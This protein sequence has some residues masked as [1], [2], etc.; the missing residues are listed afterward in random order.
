SQQPR[1]LSERNDKGI[2][3]GI[4]ILET[5]P[6]RSRIRGFGKSAEQAIKYDQHRAIVAV[7]AL[8]V[9]GVMDTM[10][11]RGIE[12]PFE[13]SKVHWHR[14]VQEELIEQAQSNHEGYSQRVKADPRQRQKE[15]EGPGELP[16]PTQPDRR[17]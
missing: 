3:A 2:V 4:A 16:R 17:R 10:M 6:E 13:R 8:L 7:E 14:C 5:E 9:R 1:P 11:G 15:H 12:H